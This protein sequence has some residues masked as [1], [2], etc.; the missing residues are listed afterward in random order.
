MNYD[1]IEIG[2]SDFGKSEQSPGGWGLA[3]DSV[4][5][6][7]ENFPRVER[8]NKICAAISNRNGRAKVYWVDSKDILTHNLPEWINGYNTIDNPHPKVLA[9]L[10]EMGVSYLMNE[11]YC[12][13]MTWK[14]LV[15]K[16]EIEKVDFLRVNTK[17]DDNLIINSVLDY[18]AI[19][20]GKI[21]FEDT[22]SPDTGKMLEMFRYNLVEQSGSLIT[23]QREF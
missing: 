12:E 17:V 20:P 8:V 7:I 15:K 14:S 3:I 6:I 22:G 16:C 4:E 2:T 11:S 18:G 10:K 1:F 23:L 5:S 21:Q 9:A 19:L 13:V